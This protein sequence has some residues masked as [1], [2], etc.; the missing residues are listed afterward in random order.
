MYLFF[1]RTSINCCL[2]CAAAYGYSLYIKANATPALE[3]NKFG[4]CFRFEAPEAVQ[5]QVFTSF[6]YMLK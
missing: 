6:F 2:S 1:L 5:K 4:P 3:F